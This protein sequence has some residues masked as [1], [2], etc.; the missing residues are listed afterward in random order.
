M[1]EVIKNDALLKAFRREKTDF[2]P[3]WLMRQAGRY[4]PEYMAIK[5]KS[6]FIEMCKT[7]E[8]ACEV[9]MQPVN[10]FDVDAAIIFADILLPL[11]GMGLDFEFAPTGGPKINTPIRTIADIDNIRQIDPETDVGYLLEAIKLT[12]KELNGKI[13]LLGFSGAPFTLAS[14]M[15]EGGGSK[16]Y[17]NTKKLMYSDPKNWHRLMDK[18][19]DVCIVYLNAQIKAGVNGV[20]LFDSWVGCLGPLEYKEFVQMHTKKIIDNVDKSVPFINFSTNT[21]EY[22]DIISETGGDV[23]GTDWKLPL[24]E[25]WKKIGYDKAI[26]GNM[27][28]GVLFGTKEEIRKRAKDVLDRAEGRPGHVFNLGHG[29]ILGTPVDNVRYLIDTVHELSGK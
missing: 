15:I 14:Y 10:A 8:V 26:Q 25:A 23:I 21:A 19:A 29:I 20:Q 16:S 4:M 13:P 11:E 24:D 28:S 3:I 18:I 2:T 5:K 1:T 22:L 6:S 12:K 17:E 27:D 7:P 9:T